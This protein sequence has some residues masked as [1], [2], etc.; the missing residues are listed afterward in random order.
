M[1]HWQILR[2]IRDGEILFGKSG[3]QVCLT[4]EDDETA[5]EVFECLEELFD[6]FVGRADQEE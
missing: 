4:C 6:R 1:T 5:E 2:M 3:D